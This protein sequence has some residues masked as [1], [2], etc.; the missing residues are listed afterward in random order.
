MSAE[1]FG[2]AV[3]HQI[4]AQCNGILEIRRQECIVHD[5]FQPIGI[6]QLLHDPQIRHLHGWIAGGLN[7][8]CFCIRMLFD[9]C[10]CGGQIRCIYIRKGKSL[11]RCCG[12]EH[13]DGSTI[14]ILCT[15]K[16]AARLEQFH[17]NRKC[18]HTGCTGYRI[19]C[20]LQGRNNFLQFT[21]GR[22]A[23]SAVI[24]TSGTSHTRV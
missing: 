22:I 8:H 2:S 17:A 10:F 14:E 18:C 7:V 3:Y 21:S 11:L 9:L 23:L 12:R 13:S 19:V 4:C 15:Y 16:M 1:E 6:C 5:E 20:A 24:I